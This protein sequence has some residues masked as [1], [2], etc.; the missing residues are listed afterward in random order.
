[1]QDFFVMDVFQ[2]KANLG[3]PV[4]NFIFVKILGLSLWIS[5]LVLVFYL[6]LQITSVAVV[7]NDAEFSLLGLVDLP[8]TRDI[9]VVQ[10]FEN[11]CLSQC[12]LAL[13]LAHLTNVDLL[14]DS[15]H[16]V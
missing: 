5:Q 1:M 8:K 10:N 4:Q 2:C 7:H 6:R 11:L 15:K 12:L 3:K 13:F 14:N 9:W 16:F